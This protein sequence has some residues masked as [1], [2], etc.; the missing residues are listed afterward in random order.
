MVCPYVVGKQSFSCHVAS[1]FK[2]FIQLSKFLLNVLFVNQLTILEAPWLPH[3][4]E[5]SV[6]YRAHVVLV[7][8]A[9]LV[10]LKS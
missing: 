1:P 2:Q 3:L 5:V 9:D 7:A 10:L 8:M 4:S 6:F